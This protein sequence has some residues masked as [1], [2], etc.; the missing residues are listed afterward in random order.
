MHP[1]PN[2]WSVVCAIIAQ[3]VLA[4]VALWHC[5]PNAPQTAVRPLIRGFFLHLRVVQSAVTGERRVLFTDIAKSF[6]MGNNAW[7]VHL[8]RRL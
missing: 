2:E 4:G 6:R 3:M 7:K 8:A 1:S 5:I